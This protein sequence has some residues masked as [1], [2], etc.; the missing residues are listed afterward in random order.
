MTLRIRSRAFGALPFL[1]GAVLLAAFASPPATAAPSVR[2]I[3]KLPTSFGVPT[4][5]TTYEP[6]LAQLSKHVPPGS[7]ISL[8]DV[9]SLAVPDARDALKHHAWT[10]FLRIHP[11]PAV[12]KGEGQRIGLSAVVLCKSGGDMA[13][14]TATC[15]LV[16]LGTDTQFEVSDQWDP[17]MS[18]DSAQV[19]EDL[20]GGLLARYSNRP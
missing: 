18:R 7:G 15:Y 17:R 14:M 19:L 20:I 5:V 8:V 12:L 16:D 1:L 13:G 10:G 2:L 11:D 4:N 6:S 9:E 3:A